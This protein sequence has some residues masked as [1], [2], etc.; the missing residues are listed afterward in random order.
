MARVSE[1]AGSA[2][3][4]RDQ[5]GDEDH[6]EQRGLGEEAHHHF[7]PRAER[8]ERGADIHRR[9]RHEHARRGEQADE[10]DGIG[11][12]R[13]RQRV[14]IEGMIAA[15]RTIVPNTTYGRDAKQ[16]RG[17]RREHGVLVEELAD[18]AIRQQ[19]RRRRLVLQPGAALVDPAQEQ[20]RG[21]RAQRA[22]SRTCVSQSNAA[23]STS[24][25]STSSVTK[26]YSR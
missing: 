22:R 14:P 6:H 25:S 10:R 11:G 20:R 23:H 19:Q 4:A 2:V 18:A 8:A 21:Q 26:L 13:E 7:A 15:A 5:R 12:P 3:V 1:I 16:R 9:E 24:A 17:V